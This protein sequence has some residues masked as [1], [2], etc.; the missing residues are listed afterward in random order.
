[1]SR[2]RREPLVGAVTPI[3]LIVFVVV[4][5]LVG[6]LGPTSLDRTVT[7]SLVLGFLA[8]GFYVF[9]GVSGV[10]SFGQLA[11][12]TVGGYVTAWLTIPPD[13]K[14]TLLSSAPQWVIDLEINWIVAV[15][16]SGLVAGLIALVL[17]VPLMR[18]NGLPA[19]LATVALLFIAE[20]VSR[21]WLDLTRGSRG[22]AGIPA[23]TDRN[24]ALG[25]LAAVIVLAW[26]YQR[27]PWGM[28]L[29]ASSDDA[30]AAEAIGVHVHRER[31][32]AFVLS[33]FVMGAGGSL[34]VQFLGTM[35]PSLFFVELSFI[36]ISMAVVGGIASL[37]GVIV[38]VT[39]ISVL[40]EVLRRAEAG[41]FVGL[42]D[43]PER[44]GLTN[45][46]LAL[47]LILVLFWRRDGLLEG[48]ELR[49]VVRWPWGGRDTGAGQMSLET[50]SAAGDA[51]RDEPEGS[52][53]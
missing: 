8:V 18:L 32:I 31:G 26:L 38:G 33:G 19:G 21:G 46:G 4:V 47:A 15:L 16:V 49:S 11:F 36:V 51:E 20:T 42:F 30:N 34:Y 13:T 14:R 1:M 50:S 41:S 25:A 24:V 3:G 17:S 53:D 29:R 9:S 48:R 2:S 39:V 22:L 28:R 35:I 45:T 52:G 12:A 27:S 6:S 23:N 10:V 40:T 43:V 5:A 44:P 7:S 37:S